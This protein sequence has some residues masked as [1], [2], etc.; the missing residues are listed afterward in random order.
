MNRLKSKLAIIAAAALAAVAPPSAP[1]PKREIKP[2]SRRQETD[3]ARIAKA[4]AKREMRAAKRIK[5]RRRES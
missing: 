4:K 1:A 5:A 3:E 2:R